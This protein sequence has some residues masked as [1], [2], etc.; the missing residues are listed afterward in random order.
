MFRLVN[1]QTHERS[2]DMAVVKM[3]EVGYKR[4][5]DIQPVKVTNNQT[6]VAVAPGATMREVYK[7]K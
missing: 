6:G 4:T 2:G 1:M 5:G 3:F 7:S